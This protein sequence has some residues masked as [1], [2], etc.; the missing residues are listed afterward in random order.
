M[1]G[2]F[3]FSEPPLSTLDAGERQRLRQAVDVARFQQNEVLRESGEQWSHMYLVLRGRV[4]AQA[5]DESG[6]SRLYGPDELVGPRDFVNGDTSRRFVALEETACLS[7][8]AETVAD[9]VKDNKAF[10]QAM[11]GEFSSSLRLDA[12]RTD[13]D[14]FALA[15]VEDATIRRAVVFPADTPAAEGVTIIRRREADCILV[16]GDRGIGMVTG[17]DLLKAAESDDG[18]ATPMGRIA[19]WDLISI[20]PDDYL[21]DALIRMTRAHIERLVVLDGDE[22]VGILDIT[23]VLGLFST[24]SHSLGIRIE[25]AGSMEEL[26]EV[27]AATERLTRGLVD[28]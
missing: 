20:G 27:S 13:S 22:L 24:Q 26:E 9:L 28:R 4:E 19:S 18:L 15:R 25:R 21:F 2:F 1:T 8:G 11:S 7:V 14:T 5:Q 12:S 3:D 6:G 17:T 23:D 16:R 10:R